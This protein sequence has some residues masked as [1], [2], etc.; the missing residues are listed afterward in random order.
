MMIDLA[1]KSMRQGI[2]SE[3]DVEIE[4]FTMI[5][6]VML[7]LFILSIFIL[8]RNLETQNIVI[9]LLIIDLFRES[10]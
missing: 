10:Y 7:L 3:K 8:F 6:A 9:L 4:C 2:F 5:A 1:L